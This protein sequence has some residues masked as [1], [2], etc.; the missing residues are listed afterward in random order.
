MGDFLSYSEEETEVS[1]RKQETP[2]R[3]LRHFSGKGVFSGNF[4]EN[5][6]YF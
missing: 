4:A 5:S 2:E 6:V 1:E 3:K